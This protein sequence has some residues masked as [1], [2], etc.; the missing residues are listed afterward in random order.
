MRLV[1]RA[2]LSAVL[3]LDMCLF[4]MFLA[5]WQKTGDLQTVFRQSFDNLFYFLRNHVIIFK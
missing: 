5:Q 4:G 1:L 3:V 2:L